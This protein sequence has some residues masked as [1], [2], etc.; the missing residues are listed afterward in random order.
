M[1]RVEGRDQIELL[2]R[3]QLGDIEHLEAGIRQAHLVGLDASPL[4]RL[5][6]EVIADER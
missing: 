5:D 1:D 4:D 3:R 6:V 2:G